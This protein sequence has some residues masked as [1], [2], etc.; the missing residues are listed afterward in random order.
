MVI[1]SSVDA[2]LCYCSYQDE[3]ENGSPIASNSCDDK[4]FDLQPVSPNSSG[5]GLPYAPEGWPNPG[6]I[7]GWKV[8]SRT[9]KAGYFLDRHLYPPKSL[10]I[11]SNKRHS[12]R[13]KPDIER[14]IESNFPSM[15]IEA[16]F[17]L[18][19]W[20]IPSTGKTPTKAVQSTPITP[21]LKAVEIEEDTTEEISSTHRKLK[22][23]TQIRCQSSRKS[24]RLGVRVGRQSLAPDQDANDILDLCILDD[25]VV[26]T[27]TTEIFY[28]NMDCEKGSGTEICGEK[29]YPIVTTVLENFEDYLDNLED[30]LVMP[31]S[32][33][34]S[35]H[36]AP[37]TKTMD[38]QTIECCKK[39]LSTLLAGDFSSLVSCNHAVIEVAMLASQICKDDTLSA[40]QIA[41]L[42]LVEEI[43]L[44]SVAFH[45]ASENVEK[46]DKFLGDL[47]AKKCKV[48]SLKSDYKDKVAQLQSEMEKNTSAIQEIDDQIQKLQSK[49]KEICDALEILQERKVEL[50]SGE[51]SV[52][53]SI[54]KLVGEIQQGLSEKSKWEL[55][56]AISVQSVAEIQEKFITLRGL[57]F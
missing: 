39:K 52:A 48:M 5:E 53:N 1:H 35:D 32:Q 34:S 18:F 28:G 4:T 14:Y 8:L 15:S 31:H 17:D 22:R 57:T 47:E 25:E 9:N 6:D 33:S 12:L 38:D 13:T 29:K 44:A 51:S 23:R 43:P 36:V 37:S 21:A 16:F 46:A 55:K 50:T 20:Q 26:K 42:K 24:S 11:P 3:K 54:L 27:D 2:V 40:D 56:K 19:S 7:W 10:Q 41:K 49:R 45:E 30:M